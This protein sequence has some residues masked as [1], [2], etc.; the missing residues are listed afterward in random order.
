MVRDLPVLQIEGK[1]GVEVEL[2]GGKQWRRVRLQG[3]RQG[4]EQLLVQ[5]DI[6][7]TQRDFDVRQPSAV[8]LH[9]AVHFD[10]PGPRC[11][12]D[13]NELDP[14]LASTERAD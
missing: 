5:R 8:K 13:I 2:P 4:T 10:F 7:A 12:S 3:R 14:G 9:R 1:Q 11:S 6:P